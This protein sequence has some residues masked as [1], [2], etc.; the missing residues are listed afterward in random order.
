MLGAG[1]VFYTLFL[2]L[3]IALFCPGKC[4]GSGVTSRSSD[5]CAPRVTNHS[6]GFGA[7][8]VTFPRDPFQCSAFELCEERLKIY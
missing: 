2:P 8:F 5:I 1:S 6:A 7:F 4:G 3:P